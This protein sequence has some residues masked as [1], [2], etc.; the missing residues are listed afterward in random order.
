MILRGLLGRSFD[1]IVC[2]RG[3]A[4]LGELIQVSKANYDYQRE[5][6]D[7]H[8]SDINT[9]L[10]KGDTQFFPEIILSYR[11][12]REKDGIEILPN[13]PILKVSDGSFKIKIKLFPKKL[14][15]R[16]QAKTEH[17]IVS[18][19]VPNDLGAGLFHRID[20][21]HRLT[22]GSR[23]DD[24]KKN[25]S[26]P[27]CLILLN[28]NE[29]NDK[30][31]TTIFHNINTKGQPLT[32][33][34]NLRAIFENNR[35]TD[36]ELE[37]KFGAAYVLARQVA[38]A[39]DSDYLKDTAHL[40]NMQKNA[41]ALGLVKFL[42]ASNGQN[43]ELSEIKDCLNLVNGIYRNEAKL[44][45]CQEQGL[46]FAFMFFAF[47]NA[48]KHELEHFKKW[49]LQNNFNQVNK[50][51]A[52]SIVDIFSQL[53]RSE[54][55]IFMAMQ[56]HET[57]VTSHNQALQNA[58]DLIRQNNPSLNLSAHP[59]M[60]EKAPSKNL[61]EDIKAKITSCNIFIADISENN[62]NVLYEF[63]IAEGRGKDCIL[64][65][66][67]GSVPPKSDYTNMLYSEYGGDFD[68]QKTLK[69]QIEAVLTKQGFQVQA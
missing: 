21:N 40:F 12:S 43:V 19:N 64:L 60:Q 11:L 22:A 63:G 69:T 4:P 37:H 18:F 62:A 16:G 41:C 5:L 39:F 44:Q 8:V 47:N 23:L 24:S 20:G 28:D 13:Q 3:F 67:Q 68:L 46:F 36:N 42:V 1:G 55:T 10:D 2:I 31:A 7:Q 30:I 66:K 65:R 35:F 14:G 29:V 51:D 49:V 33:E 59:I 32:S 17:T 26:T 25:V 45:Q 15:A 9:F 56:W 61:I 34:E 54:I 6:D 52:Q 53:I 57:F 27:F 50:V 38:Q 48:A 58:V